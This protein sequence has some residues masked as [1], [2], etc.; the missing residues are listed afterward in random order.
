LKNSG[1]VG[2]AKVVIRKRE[3]LAAVKPLGKALVLE[4]MH[5]KDELADPKDLSL[6]KSVELGKKEVSMAETL[7]AGMTGKWDPSQYHDQYREALVKVIE[8][9]V[10][11]GGKELP[12]AKGGPAKPTKIIDLVAVLQASLNQAQTAKKNSRHAPPPKRRKAA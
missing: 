6:P 9:K 2:I 1:K 10:A 11:A 7:I 3:H 12:A 5:F 4:L 8:E